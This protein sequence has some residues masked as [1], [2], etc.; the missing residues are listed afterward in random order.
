VNAPPTAND[1]LK[2][3]EIINMLLQFKLQTDWPC[4]SEVIQS[5]HQY[6]ITWRLSNVERNLPKEMIGNMYYIYYYV[7]IG[8]LKRNAV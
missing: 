2:V 3:L 1:W 8:S 6:S 5:R 7:L 4:K